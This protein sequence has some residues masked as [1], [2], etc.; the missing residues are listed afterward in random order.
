[1]SGKYP[2]SSSWSRPKGEIPKL[3]SFD[4]RRPEL[5]HV[6]NPDDIKSIM[7][8]GLSSPVFLINGRI[9]LDALFTPKQ[10]VKPI[11]GTVLKVVLPID[12]PLYIDEAFGTINSVYSCTEIPSS[13]ITVEREAENG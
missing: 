13:M 10:G 2:P 4:S 6:A 9:V 5:F 3:L 1:M 7:K 12:W 8:R 11:T